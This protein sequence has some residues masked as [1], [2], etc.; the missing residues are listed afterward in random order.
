MSNFKSSNTSQFRASGNLISG[1][2]TIPNNIMNDIPSMGSDA[3][4]VFA[5]ILQYISN[6]EHKI[7]VQGL[8]TQTGLTTGRVSKGL[9]KLIDIG[10]ILRNP[11][12]DGNLTRGYEYIVYDSP[13]VRE[14]VEIPRGIENRD[15]D[16]SDSEFRDANNKNNNNKNN[17]NKNS[18]DVVVGEKETQLLNLYKSFN[19]EKRVMPHT[20]KLLKEN[21]HID[22]DVFEEIFIAA[23]EDDVKKKFAYI[24]TIVNALN[25]ANI[26]TLAE[27]NSINEKFKESKNTT[28][29]KG[30]YTPKKNRFH[31]FTQRLDK[32][33]PDELEKMLQD[34]QGKHDER[35]AAAIE[36]EK[37]KVDYRK[38]AIKKLQETTIVT[39]TDDYLWK[40]QI[41]ALA[42]QLRNES[43]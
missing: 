23:S 14:S 24:R 34:Q 2:T 16:I 42:I 21:V 36:A 1:W 32:Y 43:M 29:S 10:Y 41:D 27:F 3:F 11:I 37:P 39:V 12:K 33:N 22:L 25:K 40:P 30:S 9:N 26:K 38:L 13:Q 20:T 15:S 4:T 19:L 17:N 5:K 6:P 7:S 28:K 18:V 35:T 8:A 31:N